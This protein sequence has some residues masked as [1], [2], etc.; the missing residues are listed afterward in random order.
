MLA[1]YDFRNKLYKLCLCSSEDID[2]DI[3]RVLKFWKNVNLAE[4]RKTLDRCVE[5]QKAFKVICDDRKVGVFYYSDVPN[6]DD[7]SNIIHGELC[8]ITPFMEYRCSAMAL[9][10]IFKVLGMNYIVF[11]PA[12]DITKPLAKIPFSFLLD[13]GIIHSYKSGKL[14]CLAI[15]KYSSVVNNLLYKQFKYIK[16][17]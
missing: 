17:C 15:L 12:Y 13:T 9:D 3:G 14:P 16:R 2:E 11:V 7:Y 1:Q 4:R 10:Y 8:W 5:Q 6:T